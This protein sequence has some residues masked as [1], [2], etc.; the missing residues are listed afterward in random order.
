MTDKPLTIEKELLLDHKEY[1]LNLDDS[2]YNLSVEI[3]SNE[4][5]LFKLTQINVLSNIQ[6]R[7]EFKYKKIMEEV[8]FSLDKIYKNIEQVLKLIDNS[9]TKNRCKLVENKEKKNY[10]I[11]NKNDN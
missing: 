7:K 8:L 9:I 11:T 2:T 4:T 3:Y 1:E 10:I 5:I 6:Y